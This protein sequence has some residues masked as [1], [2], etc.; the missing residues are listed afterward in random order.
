MGGMIENGI[1]KFSSKF[2]NK[3]IDLAI[4]VLMDDKFASALADGKKIAS[5]VAKA[6]LKNGSLTDK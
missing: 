3:P 1:N 4:D 6:P 5:D 2:L